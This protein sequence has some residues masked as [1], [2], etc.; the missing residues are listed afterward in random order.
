MA[1]AKSAPEVTIRSA[2]PEDAPACGHICYEAFFAVA[3]EHNYPPDFPNAE[4]AIELLGWMFSHP[5]FYCVVAELEGRIVGSNCLDERNVVSGVGPITVDPTVQNG[6]IGGALMRAVM[7]R[8]EEQAHPGVRLVQAGYHRRSLSLYTKLGFWTRE[9]LV[10]LTGEPMGRS[11]PG[12]TIRPAEQKDAEACNSLCQ[13]VHGFVRAG[14]FADAVAQQAA[15]LTEA[16]GRVVAYTTGLG[17]FGHSVGESTRDL[18]ALIA[19]NRQSYIGPGLIIPS[20]NWELF[21]WCLGEGLRVVESLT[22]MTTGL[23]NEP[24]GAW[25]PSILY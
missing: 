5:Q 1:I 15:T 20:R 16:K 6:K 11:V 10:A 4:V 25:M 2:R 23:Y 21:S 13:R 3:R 8:G 7:R 17:F 18:I 14:E 19:A 22:L 9:H 12:Y 24:A